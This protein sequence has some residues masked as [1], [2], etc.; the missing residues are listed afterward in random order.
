[1]KDFQVIFN[2]VDINRSQS[3]EAFLKKELTSLSEK[4]NFI[5]RA[6]VFLRRDNRSDGKNSLCEIRLSAPG[7]RLYADTNA[8]DFRSATKETIRDLTDQLQKR[9]REF[10]AGI[11]S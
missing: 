2:Y 11:G 8:E 3:L 10:T 6:D 5:H 1:M 4:Y 7:P 9:K